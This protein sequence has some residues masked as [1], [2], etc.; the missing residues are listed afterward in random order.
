MRLFAPIAL[1]AGAALFVATSDRV[2]NAQ[3]SPMAVAIDYRVVSQSLPQALETL[4]RLAGV[5]VS[6]DGQVT[7][8]LGA[9]RGVGNFGDVLDKLA[10]SH[11]LFVLY[12]GTKVLVSPRS[13]ATSVAIALNG[14][15]PKAIRNALASIYPRAPKDALRFNETTGMALVLGPRSF[16]ETV[17]KLVTS[18]PAQ[19]IQIIRA[20]QN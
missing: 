8:A 4:G 3:T 9:W 15:S 10:Q 1:F 17:Q 2:V 16:V 20:G 5:T 7:G 6:V 18:T 11:D 19:T 13:T 14:Q 12:D